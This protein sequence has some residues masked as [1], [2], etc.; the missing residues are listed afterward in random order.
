VRKETDVLVVGGGPAGAATAI[1]CAKRGLR[2]TLVEAASKAQRRLGESLSALATKPLEELGVLSEFL[3][4]EHARTHFLRT[5]WAGSVVERDSIRHGWG[6]DYHLDRARFDAWLLARAQQ[7]GACVVRA[8]GNLRLV[9]EARD[10]FVA[11]AESN[12]EALSVR[13]RA[14]IDATGRS[15]FAMRQLGARLTRTDRLLAFARWFER[16]NTQAMVLVETTSEGWWY[17]APTPAAGQV[18]A[19][20]TDAAPAARRSHREALWEKALELAPLTSQVIGNLDPGPI[21]A[22]AASPQI[23]E[24]IPDGPYLPVGDAAFAADPIGG[25]GLV[26][27]L[28]SGT[29]AAR[30]L[31]LYFR[32]SP[33]VL[34]SY[35][36]GVRRLFTQHLAERE[37]AYAGE[38]VFQP[39]SQFWKKRRN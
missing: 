5:S 23:T 12:G 38:R 18:A 4:Q 1:A 39:Q 3:E 16:R 19:F 24:W 26:L 28:S 7:Q 15:A 37:S 2:T 31:E 35:R 29:E 17:S 11:H 21:E 6:P 34:Q 22:Y 27:A 14:V 33:N 32:G 36:D 13:A 20:F 8:V 25:A 10:R 9:R 30:A